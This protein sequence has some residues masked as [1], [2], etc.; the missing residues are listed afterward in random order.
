MK[1]KDIKVVISD[2]EIAPSANSTLKILAKVSGVEVELQDKN[3]V[4]TYKAASREGAQ[5]KFQ[6]FMLMVHSE[7]KKIGYDLSD[8]RSY[9]LSTRAN[10]VQEVCNS[11]NNLLDKVKEKPICIE[12]PEDPSAIIKVEH[13]ERGFVI[14]T[15]SG[16]NDVR[17][18]RVARFFPEFIGST[19]YVQDNEMK[20]AFILNSV[21]GM[22]GNVIAETIRHFIKN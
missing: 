17:D 7:V 20:R 10:E 16:I 4:V 9:I 3:L 12:W 15:N 8:I 13:K 2:C 19:V 14:T 21:H 22:A 18:N 11:L 5:H 1:N 6:T